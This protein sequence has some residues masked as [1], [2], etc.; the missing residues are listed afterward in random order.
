[1][2]AVFPPPWEG[3]CGPAD[4]ALSRSFGSYTGSGYSPTR[5]GTG[6]V[7]TIN[8]GGFTPVGAQFPA[9][10]LRFYLSGGNLYAVDYTTGTAY[11]M[12]PSGVA[13]VPSGYT[14]TK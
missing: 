4:P 13:P 7:G 14:P 11:F 6:E 3:G 1:M 9:A 8:A 2:A 12:S 10:Q 5:G